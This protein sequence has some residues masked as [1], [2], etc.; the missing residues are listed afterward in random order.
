MLRHRDFRL[1]LT[2]AVLTQL[3]A[4][5]AFTTMLY[6]VYLLTESTFQVAMIGAAQ[7]IT[8]LVIS[9]FAGHMADKLDRKT[10]LHVSQVIALLSLLVLSLVTLTGAVAPIHIVATAFVLSIATTLDRPVRLSVF[11]TLLPTK[12]LVRGMAIMN[13]S[14]QVARLVGPGL[15]GVLLAMGGPEAVYLLATITYLALVISLYLIQSPMPAPE[16]GGRGPW[17]TFVAGLS[18]VRQQP[19]IVHFLALDISTMVFAAYRVVLPA[20]AIEIL[21]VG[22]AAYG[23]LAAIPSI[24]A[25]AGGLTVFRISRGDFPAGKAVV[26]TTIGYGMSAIALSQSQTFGLSLA[27]AAGLGYFDSISTSLRHSVVLME[28]PDQLRG[29][30]SALHGMATGG[31]PPLGDL[32]VGWLAGVLGAP[33]AL[34][35]GGL[36]PVI[37]GIVVGFTAR[38]LRDYRTLASQR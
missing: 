33:L 10:L 14:R 9:P 27:A 23:L 22:P 11:P 25:L 5:A 16:S 4:Y 2:G 15:G 31:G 24:G 7:G 30:V 17:A 21:E 34:A 32:N 20:L 8:V 6:Q 28:T 29:R 38:S 19:I 13:S 37:Y 35:L 1:Y 12:D 26:L 18:F 36:V 3:G